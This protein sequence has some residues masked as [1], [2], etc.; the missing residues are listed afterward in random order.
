MRALSDYAIDPICKCDPFMHLVFVKSHQED[1]D[2]HCEIS[3][4]RT[5]GSRNVPVAGLCSSNGRRRRTAIQI[6]RAA[7]QALPAIP[8]RGRNTRPRQ[9][10]QKG[11]AQAC[12]FMCSDSTDDLYPCRRQLDTG[13]APMRW[14][15]LASPA[16][17]DTPAP[18]SSNGSGPSAFRF[19]AENL[20]G[21]ACRARP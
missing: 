13:S 8:D 21:R 2:S 1:P 14:W 16:A 17:S 15:L 20:P 6:D 19:P 3:I 18:G 10:T 12:P 9:G 4:R 7:G 5:N 11:R